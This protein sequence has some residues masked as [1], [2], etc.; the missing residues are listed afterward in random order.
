MGAEDMMTSPISMLP[1]PTWL[2]GLTDSRARYEELLGWPVSIQVGRRDL[3]LVVGG[4]IGA[5]GMPARLGVRVRQELG[6][7]MLCGPVIADPGGG[8]WTF[9]TKPVGVL[10]ADVAGDLA[11]VRVRVVPRGAYVEIPNDLNTT[12]LRGW[13]WVER[14]VP[15]RPLPPGSVAVAMVRRLTHDDGHL[16]A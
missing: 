15:N 3:V 1:A 11:A 8:W 16:A 2:R 12:A 4:R 6:F 7:A 14:P 9:L 5:I 10:R 13:R